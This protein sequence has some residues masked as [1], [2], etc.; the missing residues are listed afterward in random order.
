[1][2]S[3]ESSRQWGLPP[4]FLFL[5]TPGFLQSWYYRAQCPAGKYGPAPKEE[6]GFNLSLS[7]IM[8]TDTSFVHLTASKSRQQSALCRGGI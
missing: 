4:S 1:M 8:D 3:E 5:A 6:E 2:K 7:K